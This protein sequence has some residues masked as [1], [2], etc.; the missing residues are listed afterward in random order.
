M[1]TSAVAPLRP[2]VR[3]A[4][5]GRKTTVAP[6]A[7]KVQDHTDQACYVDMRLNAHISTR[8]EYEQMYRR[9]IEVRQRRDLN[10]PAEWAQP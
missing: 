5:P 6:V 1:R 9:S 3:A 8:A 10:G 4:R 2:S 7:V